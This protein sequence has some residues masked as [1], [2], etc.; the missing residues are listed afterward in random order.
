MKKLF[1]II[2]GLALLSPDLQSQTIT[3]YDGNIYNTVTI[4]NQVWMK[5]NLKVTRY[6][7]GVLIPNIVDNTQW[8]NVTTG[9]Y[10]YSE[11]N[12]ITAATYGYLY[13]WFTINDTQKVC[14]TGWHI[15][16]DVEWTNLG[17]ILG[18]DAIAGGKMKE[19]GTTHWL[20][21]NTGATNES[22]FTA[23]PGGS[24]YDWGGFGAV[25]GNA[26]FW[27]ST[28]LDTTYAHYRGLIYD[29]PLLSSASD[30][31]RKGF[32]VRCLKDVS[33]QINENLNESP[34]EIYPNPAHQNIFIN[35]K[36]AHTTHFYLY[37]V[38]GK[39]LIQNDLKPGKNEI[40]LA[41]FPSGVF[42]IMIQSELKTQ[43]FKLIKN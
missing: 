11:N 16:T 38:L 8:S 42:V 15:P 37:N 40:N 23:L 33:T 21:P 34:T 27:S 7:N 6:L 17:N 39:L 32:S 13:N 25:G 12:A 1:L 10:C 4:G 26:N 31:K 35:S 9:A 18:G 36:E 20:T 41:D 43:S 2:A 22:N 28:E 29:Y 30:Y 3:D 5:E 14:P 24:R 19:T